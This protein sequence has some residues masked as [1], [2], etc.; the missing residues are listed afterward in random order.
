M[1]FAAHNCDLINKMKKSLSIVWVFNTLI[2]VMPCVLSFDVHMG[3]INSNKYENVTDTNQGPKKQ[4]P[5]SIICPGEF[6][7]EALMINEIRFLYMI[8]ATNA[9]VISIAKRGIIGEVA[10]RILPCLEDD[11]NSRSSK[12]Y[13][14]R[15]HHGDSSGIIGFDTYP[16]ITT[17]DDSKFEF[18]YKLLS[19]FLTESTSQSL[20]F[21][22]K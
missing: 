7:K 13:S 18:D 17:F 22:V 3:Q 6:P 14:S 10:A 21:V 5:F 9:S 16:G 19:N 11:S 15:L 12:I 4:A 1:A 20:F 2:L 8:E